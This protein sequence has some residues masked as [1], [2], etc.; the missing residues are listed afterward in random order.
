[1]GFAESRAQARLLVTHGHF[2][3]N[4]RRTDVP[5][6]SLSLEDEISVRDGSRKRTYFKELR[7]LAEDKNVPDWL[8]R[9]LKNL[10]GKLIRLPERIEIDGN[11]NEQLIVEYYSQR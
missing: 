5:S 4:G 7:D 8:T 3:V 1:M 2:D 9:D 10:S 11:L 6:M